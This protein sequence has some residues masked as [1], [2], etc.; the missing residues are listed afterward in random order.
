MQSALP[1]GEVGKGNVSWGCACGQTQD[2]EDAWFRHCDSLPADCNLAL[3]IIYT[4]IR[5]RPSSCALTTL[6]L[7]SLYR[8]MCG[9]AL[10]RVACKIQGGTWVSNYKQKP[11]SIQSTMCLKPWPCLTMCVLTARPSL[12]R[13][14]MHQNTFERVS[15]WHTVCL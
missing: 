14:P 10:Q 7:H 4:F 2:T 6:V 12:H 3:A 13:F 15:R 1:T 8:A 11:P 5:L 9:N